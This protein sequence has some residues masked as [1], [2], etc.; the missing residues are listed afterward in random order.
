MEG[1]FSVACES[2]ILGIYW[3]RHQYVDADSRMRSL[4]DKGCVRMFSL[5]ALRQTLG[6]QL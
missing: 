3:L 4:L 5:Y 2:E 6:E 1:D